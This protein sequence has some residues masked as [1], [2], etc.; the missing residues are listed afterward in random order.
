MSVAEFL[1]KTDVDVTIGKCSLG[2]HLKA[3]LSNNKVFIDFN[4]NVK[5][6]KDEQ[7]YQIGQFMILSHINR[8]IF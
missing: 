7:K 5:E 4:K 8:Y 3:D 1:K 6:L 2:N